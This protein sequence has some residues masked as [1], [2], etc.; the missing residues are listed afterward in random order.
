MELF[1]YG[2]NFKIDLDIKLMF[3][4]FQFEKIYT[5]NIFNKYISTLIQSSSLHSVMTPYPLAPLNALRNMCI[6]PYLCNKI[7]EMKT[8]QLL[9]LQLVSCDNSNLGMMF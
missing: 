6:V 5:G 8:I 9:D 4:F 1:C 2:N 7:L 3:V